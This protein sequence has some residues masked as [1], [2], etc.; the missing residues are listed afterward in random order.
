M[1]EPHIRKHKMQNPI[2]R[3]VET[4]LIETDFAVRRVL[5][6]ADLPAGWYFGSGLKPTDKCIDEALRVITSF[7][8]FHPSNIEVFPREDGGIVVSAIKHDDV[9]DVTCYGMDYFDVYIERAS[10]EA[11]DYEGISASEVQRQI[12][13][14]GWREKPPYGY[15][16][17]CTTRTHANASIAQL[18]NHPKTDFQSLMMHAQ[19][20]V[21]EKSAAM[22]RTSTPKEFQ[23]I[24][25]S[26]SASSSSNFPMAS[27]SSKILQRQAMYVTS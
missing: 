23:A 20:A 19:L 16:I 2:A 18:F 17:R 7:R 5:S 14:L 13:G 15:S 22:Y 21:Q 26:F 3:F 27:T 25:Q 24:P 12:R 9:I 10:A 11:A 4:A 8:D 6:F 1:Y